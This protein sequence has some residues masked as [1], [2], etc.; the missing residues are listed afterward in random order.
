MSLP[1]FSNPDFTVGVIFFIG[2]ACRPSGSIR[3]L[4]FDLNLLK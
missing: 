1:F 4:S 2:A 3:C